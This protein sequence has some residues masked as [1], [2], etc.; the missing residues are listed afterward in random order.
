M[1]TVIRLML[2][3][4]L[5]LLTTSA[6]LAADPNFTKM[7]VG[8]LV[9]FANEHKIDISTVKTEAE[10][11]ATVQAGWTK[12]QK[13]AEA[14]QAAQVKS[15]TPV[16]GMPDP[17]MLRP[18]APPLDE[19]TFGGKVWYGIQLVGGLIGMG[20]MCFGVYHLLMLAKDTYTMKLTLPQIGMKLLIICVGL[21]ITWA[22]FQGTI[23][24]VFS[25]LWE[26]AIYTT[27]K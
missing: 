15:K 11:V 27:S 3:S 16:F 18:Q 23:L 25:S 22:V 17:D 6:A 19:G 13:P 5:L 26:Y 12:L 1:R 10:L 14:A 24:V 20:V 21:A 8:E 9:S 2:C 4:L 7:T